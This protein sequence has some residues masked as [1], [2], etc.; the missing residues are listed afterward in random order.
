MPG[1]RGNW[2]RQ[3]VTSP[4]YCNTLI[5]ELNTAKDSIR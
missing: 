3:R 5:I 2:G 1:N 4:C